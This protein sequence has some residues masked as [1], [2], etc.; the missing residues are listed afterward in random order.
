[1]NIKKNTDKK[2]G[3]QTLAADDTIEGMT[4]ESCE[5]YTCLKI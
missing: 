1:M 2:R 3:L 5:E 4:N